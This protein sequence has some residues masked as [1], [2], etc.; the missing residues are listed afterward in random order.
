MGQ[1]NGAEQW[2]AATVLT[3]VTAEP[4]ATTRAPGGT[5]DQGVTV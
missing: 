1:N 5:P 3:S 2:E 4:T